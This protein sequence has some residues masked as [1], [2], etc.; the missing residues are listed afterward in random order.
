MR[1]K[2]VI[3]CSLRGHAPGAEQIENRGVTFARCRRC[4]AD[5]V[6]QGPEWQPVPKGYRITWPETAKIEAPRSVRESCAIPM[7]PAARLPASS[8]AYILVCDDDPLIRDLLDHRLSGRGYRVGLARD[9]RD[10]L[11]QVATE[12]PDAIILDAMMPMVDGLEVLRRLREEEATRRIPVIMLTA[13][14]H[15]RD[16]VDALA[17][18]ADDFMSK[19]FIPEELLS[20]LARFLAEERV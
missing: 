4:G 1:V 8:G 15:E 20:R 13:R 14:R 10:A 3:A 5:L 16:V 7:T 6:K 18:G 9:G 12:R 17:L 11:D 19:P 2:R